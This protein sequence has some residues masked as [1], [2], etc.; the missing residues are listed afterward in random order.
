M[1]MMA[2]RAF[3][4]LSRCQR[5]DRYHTLTPPR[6]APRAC[7]R[8]D[9]S[10][11]GIDGRHQGRPVD[12]A[13]IVGF[14]F[15]SGSQIGDHAAGLRGRGHGRELIMRVISQVVS[16]RALC[17]DDRAHHLTAGAAIMGGLS[18]ADH[19]WG[20]RSPRRRRRA[21]AQYGADRA[22][23]RSDKSALRGKQ[24]LVSAHRLPEVP[25]RSGFQI[26]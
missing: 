15:R 5:S 2:G 21:D 16:A 22:G 4:Q 6:R 26:N 10:G 18:T 1:V 11:I 12:H 23:R 17:A 7:F 13:G 20:L 9:R 24:R 14:R 19:A 8:V 25:P 3:R